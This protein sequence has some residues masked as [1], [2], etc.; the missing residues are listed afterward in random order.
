MYG[1]VVVLCIKMGEESREKSVYTAQRSFPS[2][3]D[4]LMKSAL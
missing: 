3:L 1:M 2:G 4:L